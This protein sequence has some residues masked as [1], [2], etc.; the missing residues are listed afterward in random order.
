MPGNFPEILLYLETKI[1]E[2]GVPKVPEVQEVPNVQKVEEEVFF[3]FY[4]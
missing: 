1:V 3:I 4:F 2:K